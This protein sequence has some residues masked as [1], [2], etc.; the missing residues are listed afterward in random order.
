MSRDV[1]KKYRYHQTIRPFLL[2]TYGTTYGIPR[3]RAVLVDI[4]LPLRVKTNDIC[5]GSNENT[6]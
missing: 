6:G 2:F 4:F 5:D 3:L 1:G